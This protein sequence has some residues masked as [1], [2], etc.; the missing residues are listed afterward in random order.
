MKALSLRVDRIDNSSLKNVVLLTSTSTYHSAFDLP[1]YS[2][3]QRLMHS[4]HV[5][6]QAPKFQGNILGVV[7][8]A[9]LSR[10]AGALEFDVTV[11]NGSFRDS[12]PPRVKNLASTRIL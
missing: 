11:P 5:T 10:I 6:D 8:T 2:R 7:F 4:H 12:K 9:R 1:V 3:Q